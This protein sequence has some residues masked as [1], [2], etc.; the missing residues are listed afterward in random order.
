MI[1]ILSAN[2]GRRSGRYIF[3]QRGQRVDELSFNY[4][5]H[6]LRRAFAYKSPQ[7]LDF[8]STK[9]ALIVLVQDIPATSAV[10]W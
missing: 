5:Y 2:I 7:K 3:H 6:T 8:I 9:T 10:G 1:N 4:D